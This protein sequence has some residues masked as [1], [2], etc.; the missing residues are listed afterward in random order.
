MA[1][2]NF[3]A[4]EVEPNEAFDPLPSGDYLCV[5]VASDMKPTK[6]GNGAFLELE[7]EVI[8]GPF[9]GRKLWDRLNLHNPNETAVK[10]A[11][12]TLSTICRA[13]GVERVAD[14]CELH[15]RPLI[16][17]V[18]VEKRIDIDDF[19]NVVKGYKK[20]PNA[21]S[22]APAPAAP[23][24]PAPVPSTPP[25]QRPAPVAAATPAGD[26]APF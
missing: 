13:V 3:N 24:A 19:T 16:C 9:K 6:S 18:R 25:W 4:N 1:R 5:I 15:D 20:R 11:K 14:S 2:L 22:A 10:I 26:S 7:L 17:K 21:P 8:D 12:G 23:A